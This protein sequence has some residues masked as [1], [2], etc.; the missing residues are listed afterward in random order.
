MAQLNITLNQ[1]EILQLLKGDREGAFATLLQESLNAVLKAES[2]EQL[3]AEAYE[4]T[5]ERAG[6]RN[7]SRERELTTRIGTITLNVPKHRNAPFHT[8]IFDNYCRSEAALI[9]GMAEMV[10]NGVSTRKVSTVVETIC[11]KSISKSAVSDLCKDLDVAVN[12]FKNRPLLNHY[13]FVT[14]DA[15]YF[16]VREDHKIISKAFMIAYAT[17][18]E[19]RRDII[20]FGAYPNESKE[21]WTDFLQSLKERGLKDVRVFVS[22]AH[23]GIKHAIAKVFP[24]TPWQ[25][26]QF[27]FRKNIFDKM[28]KK[29]IEGLKY[30]LNEMF[31]CET[32]EEA[33]RKRDSIIADYK[34]I[35]EAAMQCLDEGFEDSMT[36]MVLPVHLRKFMRT[37]NHIER[38]NKELKRRSN[39]IGIF[40]N[41]SSLNRIMGSVLIELNERR[42]AAKKLFYT[43]TYKEIEAQTFRLIA[44]AKE[45]QQLMA[46]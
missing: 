28:P 26:C 40:P 24:D 19:G 1:E 7:G 37:S 43:P 9:A 17:N 6:Y 16:K 10:V 42:S 5:D 21:T 27:H 33:R 2:S 44:K 15:T 4:R 41:T 12:E 23:E 20:G 14:I 36:V 30:E 13:P 38:L 18:K 31:D 25:R 46:A 11:G 35:A 3:H 8:M 22:D 39:V 32:I 34:D 45:Q 29:F